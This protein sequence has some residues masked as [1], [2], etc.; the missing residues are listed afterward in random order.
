MK[1]KTLFVV[2]ADV[3]LLLEDVVVVLPPPPAE[4]EAVA[5]VEVAVAAA[6]IGILRRLSTDPEP[7]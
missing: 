7:R 5:G 1:D 6:I 3:F 2:E 4:D